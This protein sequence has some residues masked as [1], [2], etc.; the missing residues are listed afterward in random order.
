MAIESRVKLKD[1]ASAIH[2][3]PSFGFVLQ[4]IAAHASFEE[5]L[6]GLSGRVLKTL[7]R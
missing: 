2:V 6:G 7:V 1:L 3:Y 4:Q 5:S